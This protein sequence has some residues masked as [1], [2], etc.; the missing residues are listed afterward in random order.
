ML[1]YEAKMLLKSAFVNL[2]CSLGDRLTSI[3]ANIVDLWKSMGSLRILFTLFVIMLFSVYFILVYFLM[4]KN[5]KDYLEG[6]TLC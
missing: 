1:K 2:I 3:N 6:N 5:V 4:K